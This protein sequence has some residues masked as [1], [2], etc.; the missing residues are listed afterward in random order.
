LLLL[1]WSASVCGPVLVGC[2]LVKV[3]S[4]GNV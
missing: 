3:L 4:V 1:G 2:K